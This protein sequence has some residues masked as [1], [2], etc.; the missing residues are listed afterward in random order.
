MSKTTQTFEA[1]KELARTNP[2]SKITL[3][4]IVHK[5]QFTGFTQIGSI[6]I[7]FRAQE[8]KKGVEDAI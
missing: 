3:K 8:D 2:Y 7:E 6:E 4:L 1:L 5:G